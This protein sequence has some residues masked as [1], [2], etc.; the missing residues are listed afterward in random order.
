MARVR[1][2]DETR[3]QGLRR[4]RVGRTSR[5]TMMIVR[6]RSL[7]LGD[8]RASRRMLTTLARTPRSA[9]GNVSSASDE[10]MPHMHTAEA[11]H[12]ESALIPVARMNG[13]T[14]AVVAPSSG[15]TLPGQDSFI[16]LDGASAQ[17][18]L[19]IRDLAMPLNFTGDERRNSV[20][21]S[22]VESGYSSGRTIMATRSTRSSALRS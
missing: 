10:I 22:R 4:G 2:I 7:A 19:L 16:Q 1:K 11:F 21:R 12:A 6:W 15:D 18:M 3:C 8:V 5:S 14:N 13:V 20:G 9:W 17:E